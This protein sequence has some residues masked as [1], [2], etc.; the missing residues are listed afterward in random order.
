LGLGKRI[1]D[2]SS[3]HHFNDNYHDGC[4]YNN[5][6]RCAD[7]HHNHDHNHDYDHHHHNDNYCP[8]LT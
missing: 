4:A 8:W 6:H 1:C 3:D 2:P 5:D 7:D